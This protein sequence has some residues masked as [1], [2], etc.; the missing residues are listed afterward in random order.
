MEP[1]PQ[2]RMGTRGQGTG[3]G[4]T[5][6]G[7]REMEVLMA[8]DQEKYFATH[9]SSNISLSDTVSQARRQNRDKP[10]L[11]VPACTAP[12]A[13]GEGPHLNP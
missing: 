11:A 2:V 1:G 5:R 10:R 9:A 7:S 8:E 13:G 4:D 12:T 3:H 6:S